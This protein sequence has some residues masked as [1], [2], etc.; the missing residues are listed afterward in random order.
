M[1]NRESIY[2]KVKHQF[3]QT[4]D[5][6]VV[7]ESH[8]GGQDLDA[9]V[10]IA[11]DVAG[12]QV[13]DIATGGG[14]TAIALAK[15]GAFVTATDLTPEILQAAQHHAEG[16]KIEMEYAQCPAEE[17][18][19]GSGVFDLATCRIAPHHFADPEA[20]LSEVARVLRPGGTLILIDNIS[21][22]NPELHVP[23]NE[24]E[25]LRDPSHIS[26]YSTS[27]WVSWLADKGYELHHFVRWQK[28]KQFEDWTH[29]S[30]M[31]STASKNLEEYILSLPADVRGYLNVQIDGSGNV[32]SLCHEVALFAART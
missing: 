32:Q 17:M 1:K 4:A 24:I 6:Y 22:E 13:V 11:G 7:S 5:A 21:P 2:A 25:R 14:H 10:R 15:K 29:R 20:F 12:K 8:A 27:R 31:T 9:L 30:K 18:A 3:G 28:T 23:I 19:F 16:Q 26:T